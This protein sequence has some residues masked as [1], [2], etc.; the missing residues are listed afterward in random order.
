M[1]LDERSRTI[2]LVALG[3][4]AALALVGDS[5]GG[6]WFPWP[7]AIIGLIAFVWLQSPP[8]GRDGPRSAGGDPADGGRRSTYAYVAPRPR[9]P[10][11]RGP[12]L[13]WFTLLLIAVGEGVLGIV[14]AAGAPIVDSAY[15]ALAPRVSPPC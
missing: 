2:A 8:H 9:D 7:L 5:W 3:V 6:C 4:V 15:A 10:R 14:D 1:H 12:I 13:F 11:K